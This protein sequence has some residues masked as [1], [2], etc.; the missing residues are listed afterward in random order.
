MPDPTATPPP[1]DA[2]PSRAT[3]GSS[4]ETVAAAGWTCAQRGTWADLIPD[5]RVEFSWLRPS[6]LW[7][8]RNDKLARRLHDPTDDRRRLWVEARRHA[9]APADFLLDRTAWE[10]PS[11]LVLGDPG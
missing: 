2:P 9:G 1:L 3:T 7:Q 4:R 6:V 11:F 8:S 5:D 10:E